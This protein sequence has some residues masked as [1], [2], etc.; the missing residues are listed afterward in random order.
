MYIHN[1]YIYVL[2][3]SFTSKS[4]WNVKK[5]IYNRTF[6]LKLPIITRNLCLKYLNTSS[7]LTTHDSLWQ[8]LAAGSSILN[9]EAESASMRPLAKAMTRQLDYV[10]NTLREQCLRNLNFYTDEVG[11]A[12]SRCGLSLMC[13]V[14]LMGRFC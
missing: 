6:V 13:R 11:R 7:V 8:C 1:T 14:V 10:R 5:Q 9:R 3:Y 12:R 4:P 2:F